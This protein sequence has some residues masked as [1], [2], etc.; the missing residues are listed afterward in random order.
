MRALNTRYA[1]AHTFFVHCSPFLSSCPPLYWILIGETAS[2]CARARKNIEGDIWNEINDTQQRKRQRK[3]AKRKL[4]T[5]FLWLIQHIS[6]QFHS[7][8]RERGTHTTP[9]KTVGCLSAINC[10]LFPFMWSNVC[11]HKRAHTSIHHHQE[12]HREQWIAKKF[13][14]HKHR[15][16]L[17]LSLCIS[18]ALR[19]LSTTDQLNE[20]HCD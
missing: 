7:I 13:H 4:Q 19:K 6:I 18:Q 5:F 14:T 10:L 15:L 12:T 11:E 17:P 8:E 3:Y 20:M 2:L 16:Y 9:K 1:E